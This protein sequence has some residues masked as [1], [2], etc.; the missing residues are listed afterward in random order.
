VGAGAGLI[1]PGSDKKT[2]AQKSR[3]FAFEPHGL[4]QA[5]NV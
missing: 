4:I 2:A 1:A 3:R 5:Q